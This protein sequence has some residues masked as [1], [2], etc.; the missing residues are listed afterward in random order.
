MA[1]KSAK[2]IK[3]AGANLFCHYFVKYGSFGPLKPLSCRYLSLPWVLAGIVNFLS[4]G[5]E[6]SDCR[7]GLWIFWFLGHF[8][9]LKLTFNSCKHEDHYQDNII[10]KSYGDVYLGCAGI[11]LL[12]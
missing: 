3:G 8:T 10:H 9:A 7:V 4:R 5:D 11:P 12:F 2:K 6:Q 1:S